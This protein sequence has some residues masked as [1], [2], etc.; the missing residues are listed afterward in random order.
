VAE[1]SNIDVC[2]DS[3]FALGV[4]QPS[5]RDALIRGTIACLETKGYANT[6]A[7]DIAAA[8]GANLASIGYHFGSKE[9][10]LNEALIRL[11]EQR[12]RRVGK[13]AVVA[14]DG[15]PADFLSAMFT[16]AVGVFDAPRPLLAAFVEGIAQA[17]R[18]DELRQQIALHYREARRGIARTLEANLGGSDPDTMAALLLALFDGLLLQGLVDGDA[19]PS[20][21]Q[22]LAALSDLAHPVLDQSTTATTSR[23]PTRGT[24][25]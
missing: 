19:I 10:L 8:S 22:L 4:A 9:R 13:I 12:N 16:A 25:R 17:E 20:G 23:P 14:G 6:T 21:H 5:N 18:S 15:S 24:S 7:R 3:W 11:L 1:A 2:I